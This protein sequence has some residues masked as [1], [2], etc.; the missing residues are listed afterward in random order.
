MFIPLG[1]RKELTRLHVS[2]TPNAT[3]LYIV[4]MSS[5]K[6]D[7]RN[8]LNRWTPQGKFQAPPRVG[9]P[10]PYYTSIRIPWSMGMLRVLLWEGGPGLEKSPRGIIP[11]SPQPRQRAWQRMPCWYIRRSDS[12]VQSANSAAKPLTPGGINRSW[13]ATWDRLGEGLI[14][15]PKLPTWEQKIENK[16]I[17]YH[18]AFFLKMDR[19]LC[20]LRSGQ[21]RWYI[22]YREKIWKNQGPWVPL[23][24]QISRV[25]QE[26]NV[27]KM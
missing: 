14:G 18:Y 2:S 19:G 9:P 13:W 25:L 11:N 10:F 27:E 16:N 26:V 21:K 7:R 20:F 15:I 12:I 5:F 6:R 4:T 23:V 3:W 24:D 22:R 17:I 8:E 1:E